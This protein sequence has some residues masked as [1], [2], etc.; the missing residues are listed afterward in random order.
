MGNSAT[1]KI[2]DQVRKVNRRLAAAGAE[3]LNADRALWAALALSTFASVTG[4]QGDLRADPE[5]TLADL[6][7]DLMHWCD[8]DVT[9]GPLGQSLGFESALSRARRH[10]KAEHAAMSGKRTMGSPKRS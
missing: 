4:A 8:A 5:T 7:A 10:F 3:P 6:L 2:R 1:A 9:G